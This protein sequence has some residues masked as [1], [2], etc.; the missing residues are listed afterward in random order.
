MLFDDIVRGKDIFL[1]LLLKEVV[2]PLAAAMF[3]LQPTTASSYFHLVYNVEEPA[4]TAM[5]M[6]AS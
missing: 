4:T 6:T 2:V 1:V 5:T 3:E